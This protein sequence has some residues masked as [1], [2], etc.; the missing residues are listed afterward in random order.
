MAWG[1]IAFVASVGNL[2]AL[3]WSFWSL[4][5]RA[6]DES[7]SKPLLP[8]SDSSARASR[9]VSWRTIAVKACLLL[10]S[11]A[12]GASTTT[13]IALGQSDVL[14]CASLIFAVSST[15]GY[16]KECELNGHCSSLYR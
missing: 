5:H 4:P 11:A 14:D 2:V 10:V 16:R 7:E 9:R 15:S 13:R 12:L 3:G 1:A 8:H 6:T